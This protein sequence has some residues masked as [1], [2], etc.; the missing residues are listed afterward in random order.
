MKADKEFVESR[1]DII[2]VD[3]S[4]TE[5]VLYDDDSYSAALLRCLSETLTITLVPTDSQ[6]QIS[7]SLVENQD[8]RQLAANLGNN[9]SISENVA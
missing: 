8:D 3:D 9:S 5:N 4:E 6:E 2:Y 7:L 1:F